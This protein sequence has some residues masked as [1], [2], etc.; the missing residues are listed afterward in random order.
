MSRMRNGVNVVVLSPRRYGKTSLIRAAGAKLK[1]QR[2]PA[3]VVDV[4]LLRATSLAGLVGLL[5]HRAFHLPATRWQRARQAVPEFLR[6]IRVTPAVTFDAGGNPRFGF[7]TAISSR[8]ADTVLTDVYD[9]LQEEAAN[10]PAAMVLDEFQSI[11]RLGER[12]PDVFKALADEHPDVSLVLAGSKRHLM[13]ELVIR[14]HAPL[15]GMAQRLALGPIPDHEMLPYLQRRSAG[16]GRP[17]ETD[18]AA[19]LLELA[20]PVPNDIQHLAYEAFEAAAASIDVAAV[21][22]GLARAVG[23]DSA[24]YAENLAR[25]SP[26]QGRVLAAIAAHPPE[27]PYSA[28]FARRVD[29]ATAGSVR[30]ALQPLLQ[31]EDVAERDG[32]LVVT[33]PFFAYWLRDWRD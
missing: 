17:I 20:G 22:R 4:N 3:A 27:A 13:E 21:D 6:R 14:D 5:T 28:A 31:N 10:R 18:A 8:D 26:G 1:K 19:R 16:A 32:R 15:Y 30:K 24:L 33:D 12:L 25:L 23:H 7:D 9:L 29:L 2:P 11:T